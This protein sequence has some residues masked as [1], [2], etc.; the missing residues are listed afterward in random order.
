MTLLNILITLIIFFETHS[1]KNLSMCG[2]DQKYTVQSVTIY[3]AMMSKIIRFFYF[4][5]YSS[6]IKISIPQYREMI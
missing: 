4:Q 3:L 1:Q 6:K 2:Y 5:L